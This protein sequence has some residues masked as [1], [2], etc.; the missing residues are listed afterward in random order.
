VDAPPPPP[1]Y[2]H[3]CAALGGSVCIHATIGQRSIGLLYSMEVEAL[4]I[5]LF[6]QLSIKFVETLLQIRFIIHLYFF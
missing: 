2:Y 5:E 1:S 3:S 4:C 6:A